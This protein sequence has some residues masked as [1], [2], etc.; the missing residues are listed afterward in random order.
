LDG[1][2]GDS[3]RWLAD[4]ATSPEQKIEAEE[5]QTAIQHCLNNLPVEYRTVVVLA[6]I[7]GLDYSEVASVV[8]APLGTIK[9]RLARARLRLRMFARVQGTSSIRVSS[10]GGAHRMNFKDVEILSEYL[11]GQL[12]PDKLARIESRLSR[13]AELRSVLEDLR[14]SRDLMRRLPMRRPTK[15][16]AYT[17]DGSQEPTLTC[18]VQWI[19]SRCDGILPF[20]SH[21]IRKSTIHPLSR[22]LRLH[23]KQL[24]WE[25]EEDLNRLHRKHQP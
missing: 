14:G 4:P 11:D 9:S 5:L 6:D 19:A 18:S 17:F 3:P 25:A 7:Q 22:S 23:K 20:C 21:H 2:D 24:A 1:E 8:R 13:D 15:D 12:K 10:A 16:L